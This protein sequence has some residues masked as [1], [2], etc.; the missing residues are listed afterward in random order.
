M[1]STQS[2]PVNDNKDC[3]KSLQTESLELLALY[4]R[5]ENPKIRVAVLQLLEMLALEQDFSKAS[6][7]AS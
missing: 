6:T 7:E 4:Q 5:L 1:E 3:L 2:L